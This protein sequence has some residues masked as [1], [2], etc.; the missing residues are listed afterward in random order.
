MRNTF[1][2]KITTMVAK[3]PEVVLLSGDIGNRLFDDLKTNHPAQFY[4]CGVAEANMMGV[5]SGMG[6]CG[7]QPIVYTITPFVTARCLEQIKIDVAYQNSNV[8]IVGTGSG[9]SYTS[10]GPTHHSLEDFA[11]FKSIPNIRIFAP[12]DSL[13]LEAMLQEAIENPA[14]T[15]MRIGKKGEPNLSHGLKIPS[16]REGGTT[17][18]SGEKICIL[19]I[20]TIG[21]EAL[22]A[23][24]NCHSEGLNAQLVLFHTL[25]PFPNAKLKELASKFNRFITVEEHST[26]GGFGEYVANFFLNHSRNFEIIC[27]G[28]KD[29]F[30]HTV[31]S[32]SYGRSC[33]EIDQAA[34]TNTIKKMFS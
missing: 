15:Y 25:K 11:L 34:I 9:L 4:N 30:L 20:G 1:A 16:F 5:A 3:R 13:S 23:V 10:L 31:G 32:Q 28:T 14:P 6:L 22:K 7:L 21:S 26:L 17:I 19:A 18:V 2:K 33:Y 29:E 12:W 8:L 27:L 24:E